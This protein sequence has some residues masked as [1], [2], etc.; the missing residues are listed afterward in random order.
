MPDRL[1][2]LNSNI[3]TNQR[4]IDSVP[5]AAYLINNRTASGILINDGAGALPLVAHNIIGTGLIDACCT[6]FH[7][8]EP[9]G[10]GYS[11]VRVLYY[12]SF[13]FADL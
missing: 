4:Y 11:F 7:V 12:L 2:K 1:L 13:Y 6:L 8:R 5:L 3:L 10:T 9:C